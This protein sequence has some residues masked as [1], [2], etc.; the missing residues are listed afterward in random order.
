MVIAVVSSSSFNLVDA[1]PRMGV[2]VTVQSVT[3]AGQDADCIKNIDIVVIS[4]I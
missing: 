3:H 2:I 1:S 4:Y